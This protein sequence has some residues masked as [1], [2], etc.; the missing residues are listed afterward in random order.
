[1]INGDTAARLPRAFFAEAAPDVARAL[2]GHRLMRRLPDGRLLGGRIVETEGYHGLQ[3][4]ASH[5][6]SGPTGRAA[7]MFGEA[8]R[9]YVYLIYGMY[10]MLNISTAET[11]MPSAVLIRAI[12]PLIGE[13]VMRELRPVKGV[14]LSNG[15]GKLCRAMQI[16]RAL[17]NEDLIG[18]DQLWLAAGEAVAAHEVSATPRI[19]IDYAAP[20]CRDRPWRFIING[21]KWVSR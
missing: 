11:G 20:E 4:S 18:S 7:V 6:R 13:A 2:L 12:E 3:D 5:G 19:G 15:P 1:M 10:D 16:T 21:N 8:G 14:A 17:N 9:A